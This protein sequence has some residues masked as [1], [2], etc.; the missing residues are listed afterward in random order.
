[1]GCRKVVC[2]FFVVPASVRLKRLKVSQKETYSKG[3]TPMNQES[4]VQFDTLSR[5]H[6]GLA[7]KDLDRS[8][9]FYR[10]LFGQEPTMTR[11]HYAKFEV[12]EPPVNL[13]LNE[14]GGE[15]GP[16]NPVAHFGIQVKSTEV[17]KAIADRLTEVAVETRIE[18]NV[19]CCFAVQNKVWTADPTRESSSSRPRVSAWR[20]TRSRNWQRTW[21]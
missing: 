3:E 18:E 20:C 9:F 2:V 15:S 8:V 11:P 12:A 6:M 21:G 13:L 1:M 5:I 10:T 14:V 4:A 7:V 17:V 16:G 19:T